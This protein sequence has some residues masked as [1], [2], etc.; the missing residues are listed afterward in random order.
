MN[1]RQIKNVVRTAS[2][3]ANA[4]Q[5]VLGYG[6]L[7][8]VLNMM[9]QFDARCVLSRFF[10][11]AQLDTETALI[12]TACINRGIIE[13]P[14]CVV[15]LLSHLIISSKDFCF[16]QRISLKQIYYFLAK[17]VAREKG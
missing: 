1:G 13:D 8:Q 12:A 14:S 7:T 5:E 11:C 6:H 9:D 10:P 17:Q 16:C 15:V 2:A 3:L 4:R